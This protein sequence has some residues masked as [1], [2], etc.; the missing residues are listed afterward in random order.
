MQ[1]IEKLLKLIKENPEL[2]IVPMASN[3][4]CSDDSGYWEGEWGNVRIDEF[5]HCPRG[6]I[7]FR[8]DDDIFD[9]LERYL[10]DDEYERLPEEDEYEGWEE[11]YRE[12]YNSLPWKKA[13]IVD[14]EAI[15]KEE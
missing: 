9:V 11:K 10:H 5:L 2:P 15:I 14:V 12:V 7:A 13:I 8:S 6:Y 4:I 1:N 3:D